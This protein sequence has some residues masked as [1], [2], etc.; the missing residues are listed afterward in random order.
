[1]FHSKQQQE[2]T[3]KLTAGQLV[4]TN[5]NTYD[6]TQALAKTSNHALFFHRRVLRSN[7]DMTLVH[8]YVDVETNLFESLVRNSKYSILKQMKPSLAKTGRYV[9][10]RG[11]RLKKCP[12]QG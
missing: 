11:S 12:V 7:A 4:S 3:T 5:G 1:M 8:S 2:L 6:E 10:Q 9:F